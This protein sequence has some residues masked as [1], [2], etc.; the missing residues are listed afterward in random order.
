MLPCIY[1]SK[2]RGRNHAKVS[3]LRWCNFKVSDY[4]YSRHENT[5]FVLVTKITATR[6]TSRL[7]CCAV[8]HEQAYSLSRRAKKALLLDNPNFHTS[9]YPWP[10]NFR[11]AQPNFDAHV[12]HRVNY[13]RIP[14]EYLS[15]LGQDR[16]EKSCSLQSLRA[17]DPRSQEID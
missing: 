2:D 10:A 4:S 13:L 12:F 3:R 5:S 9:A 14:T 1:P 7:H 11:P 6:K 16:V 15:Y 17:H 8:L